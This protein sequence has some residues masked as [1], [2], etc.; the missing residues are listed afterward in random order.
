MLTAAGALAGI[1]WAL[2]VPSVRM[3]VVDEDQGVVLTGESQHHFVAAALFCG[4]GLVVGVLSAV[5]V[6]GVRRV[7]GP[8]AVATSVAG[9]LAAA[10]AAALTGSAVTALRFPVADAPAVGSIVALAPGI[11]TPMVLIVQPM[12]AALTYLLLAGTSP[13][14]DLDVDGVTEPDEAPAMPSPL[15]P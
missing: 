4:I 9:S 5:V 12:A 13:H 7:R 6:W 2:L 10:G 8:A 14:D 11:G 3:L 1:V 15:V